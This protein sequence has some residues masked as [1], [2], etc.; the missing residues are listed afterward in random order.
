MQPTGGGE[1]GGRVIVAQSRAALVSSMSRP[2]SGRTYQVWG[3]PSD[4]G[5]PVPLPTF[6]KPGA[7]V[8]VDDVAAYAKVAITVEPSG[9]SKTPS[10]APFAAAT[11]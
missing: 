8:I 9:G 3:L 6:S 7:V 10:A 2:P 5:E 1:A 4:G 11:L